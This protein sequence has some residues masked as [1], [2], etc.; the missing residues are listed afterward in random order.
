MPHVAPNRFNR[1]DPDQ[2]HDIDQDLVRAV[3]PVVTVLQRYFRGEVTGIENIPAG[4]A[5]LVGNHNGGITFMEPFLLAREWHLRTGGTDD[6]HYLGHDTLFKIPVFGDV[7]QRLGAVRASYAT[8]GEAFARGRKVAVW[9]GGNQESFRPWKDRFKVDF[10]GHSGFVRLAI[11]HRVPIV[12]VLSFGG[13]DTFLILRQGRRL[14][15][16][17]GAKRFLRSE[18][19]PVFL[20]L[21]WGVGVGPIFHLPLPVKLAVDVG[22][23]I[24]VEGASE[25]DAEAVRAIADQVVSTLQGMMDRRVADH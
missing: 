1:L 19:F 22:E 11:R 9:P 12:P 4:P 21:P 24:S 3:L 23:P 2:V 17:T 14:A 5:L 18:S 25:A 7:I 8:A 13:H 15:K 6:F 20:G 16:W 10:H